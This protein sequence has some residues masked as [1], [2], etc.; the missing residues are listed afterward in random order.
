MPKKQQKIIT[1][2]APSPTGEPHL[3]NIRTALFS[4]LFAR[5]YHG[6]FLL[7]IEDTDQ[8]RSVPASLKKIKQALKWLGLNWDQYFEQSKRLKFYQK[9]A[10]Q[11]LEQGRAYYCFCTPERLEKMR[12]EQITAKQPPRYDKKC[13]NLTKS[14]IN[15]LIKQ[16]TPYGIRFKIPERGKVVFNDLIRGKIIFQNQELDDQ[17]ILKSDGFPTYHL[18]AVVDDHLMKISHV[19]RGE[20]WLSSTPKH[21]LMYQALKW[22]PPKFAHLPMIL[23]P[24]KSKLSK[25]HGAVSINY[26]QEQGYL[27]EAMNNF[28]ALLGWNPG[29]NQEIFSLQELI[30]D[31][32]LKRVQKA[33]AI[34]NPDRLNW[35]NKAYIRQLSVAELTQKC[36]P[37]LQKA[38]L[39]NVKK[40]D[41]DLNQII[42]LEQ[43]RLTTLRDITELTDYFFKGKLDYQKELLLWKKMSF[44]QVKKALITAKKTIL[45][46][47]S[48]DFSTK[49]IE[50]TLLS[51]AEAFSGDRGEVLWPLRVALSGKNKSPSP[52]DIAAILGKQ[53]TLKRIQQTLDKIK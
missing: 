13:L 25:R 39:I 31:F 28:L 26:Y 5:H 43:K 20:E 27:P 24:D 29:T 52:F 51:A 47:K 30:K 46:M 7:R 44:T 10:N 40:P 38:G 16:K 18:A 53:K 2:F 19:I 33:G 45:N 48:T 14:Q 21:I 1:R 8:D 4:W 50:K 15:G 3:G 41:L 22:Q 17:V 32:S 23:G 49:N 11:F 9:Y 6:K 37:Y 12:R 34:F 35:Y 42:N 36:L